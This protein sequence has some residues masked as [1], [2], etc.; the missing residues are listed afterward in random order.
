MNAPQQQMNAQDIKVAEVELVYKTQVPYVSRTKITC[1]R[2]SYE[3]L[4]STWNQDKIELQEQFKI[5]LLNRSN[6][7]L[8]VSEISTG[9]ITGTVIDIRLI[10]STALKTNA[11]SIILCHNHPSGNVTPSLADE[12]TTTKIKNAAALMDICI[13]D[14]IILTK[15]GYYSFADEGQL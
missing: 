11:T 14:H 15:D 1:S 5:L 4:L 9:G 12:T 2:N 8:G 7:V 3:L 13:L 6:A 10:L